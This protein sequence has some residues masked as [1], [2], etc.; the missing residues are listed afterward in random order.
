MFVDSAI[1]S[2][3]FWAAEQIKAYRVAANPNRK[4][5]TKEATR[6]AGACSPAKPTN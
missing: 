5:P 3:G 1:A 4:R 2:S 6:D